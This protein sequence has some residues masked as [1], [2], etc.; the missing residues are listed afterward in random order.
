MAVKTPPAFPSR[1]HQDMTIKTWGLQTGNPCHQYIGAVPLR[2]GMGIAFPNI[3]QYHLTPFSLTDPLKEGHQRIIGLYLVDPSDAPLASTQRVPP[4]QKSWTR[5]SLETRT[6]GI[7]PVELIDK[8]LDEVA[9]VMDIDE[10][11]KCREMMVKER[12]RLAAL[13]DIQYFNI[14]CNSR[15]W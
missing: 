10:A 11:L 2:Q 9:G 5:L 8:V 12:T 7:F 3:Y 6:R 13:N 14:P 4:Q 15:G 1:G